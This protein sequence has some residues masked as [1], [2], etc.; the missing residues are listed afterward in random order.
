MHSLIC[1]LLSATACVFVASC[2][3]VDPEAPISIPGA[4]ALNPLDGVN[5][6][7]HGGGSSSFV[8]PRTTETSESFDGAY[9]V[10]DYIEVAQPKSPLYSKYPK[11]VPDHSNT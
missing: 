4:T 10:G 11:V 8:T 3:L 7:N 2:S 9:H 6:W 1:S 5:Y